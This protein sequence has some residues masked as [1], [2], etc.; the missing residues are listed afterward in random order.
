MNSPSSPPVLYVEDDD[1][2]D[3]EQN[4]HFGT[5]TSF[6]TALSSNDM[7]SS[8][9][10][11]K[12]T[13]GNVRINPSV[14]NWSKRQRNDH[15]QQ[16]TTQHLI[17]ND[18]DLEPI[19]LDPDEY[20]IEEPDTQSFCSFDWTIQPTPP[21]IIPTRIPSSPMQTTSRVSTKPTSNG[22]NSTKRSL[23]NPKV[24][25]VSTPN[26]K[27]FQQQSKPAAIPASRPSLAP[28]SLPL[29]KPTS[30]LVRPN[31]Q[32]GRPLKNSRIPHTQ[33]VR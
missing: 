32:R 1:D 9:N 8:R 4:Q 22:N 15:Y 26:N 29:P 19:L 25:P 27:S 10:K 11:R 5:N 6:P 17:D 12:L 28:L 3:N 21:P 7:N 23:D 30:S 18:T 13:H 16:A 20:I 2:D 24:I 33:S 31:V 14:V